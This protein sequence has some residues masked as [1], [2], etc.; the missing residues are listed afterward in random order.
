M[1]RARGSE[2][3]SILHPGYRSALRNVERGFVEMDCGR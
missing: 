3:E 1:S 2:L